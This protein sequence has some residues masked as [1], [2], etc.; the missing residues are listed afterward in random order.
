MTRAIA[1]ALATI[2]L[3]ASPVL[4]QTERAPAPVEQGEEL[5]GPGF[6]VIFLAIAAGLIAALALTGS[7]GDD[8]PASP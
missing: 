7:D 4:A 5:A 8:L 2:A 6:I 1:T 3:T